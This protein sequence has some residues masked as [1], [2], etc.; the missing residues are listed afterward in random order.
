[1]QQSG[2][3][4][5]SESRFR[6]CRQEKQTRMSVLLQSSRHSCLLFW[7]KTDNEAALAHIL[8]RNGWFLLGQ[9]GRSESQHVIL[10]ARHLHPGVDPP[11][12]L[13]EFGE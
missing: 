4:S 11:G 9:Q 7:V 1:M 10:L 12:F 3:L 8:N 2:Q 13:A 6:T 5:V